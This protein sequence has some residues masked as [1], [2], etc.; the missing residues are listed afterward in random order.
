MIT[1]AGGLGILCA[2]ACEAA[3]LELPA[4]TEVTRELLLERLPV[5]ASLGNPI[6]LL[7]SATASTYGAALAP[8]LARLEPRCDHRA[9]RSASGRGRQRRRDRNPGGRRAFGFRQA[10]H[11]RHRQRRRRAA[12]LAGSRLPGDRTSLP[13]VRRTGA[14]ARRRPR[15]MAAPPFRGSRGTG[16]HRPGARRERSSTRRSTRR[17]T[18]GSRPTPRG[19]CSRPTASLWWRSVSSEPPT[20]RS[21]RLAVS[22]SRWW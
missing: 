16:Q 22:A 14:R 9:L 3:G 20:T 8:L 5:E 18:A 13:R 1:N 4:L 15:G 11:R 12:R 2:D 10:R 21:R 7:G 17:R 6:D 19:R